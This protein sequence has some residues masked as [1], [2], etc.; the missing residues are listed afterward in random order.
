MFG[1]HIIL[2]LILIYLI[3]NYINC[4]AVG[5]YHIT[6]L[7]AA[8]SAHYLCSLPSSTYLAPIGYLI[9]ATAAA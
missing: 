3:V 6:F 1:D 2:S 5:E 7:V 9:L 8:V 4:I